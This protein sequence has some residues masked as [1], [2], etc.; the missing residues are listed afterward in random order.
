MIRGKIELIRLR[1]IDNENI[2]RPI[3]N[4]DDHK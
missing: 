4:R 1:L 2:F 3:R